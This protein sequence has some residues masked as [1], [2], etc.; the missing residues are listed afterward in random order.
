MLLTHEQNFQVYIY[1]FINLKILFY[2]SCK[3]IHIVP[4]QVKVFPKILPM[5]LL[6]LAIIFGGVKVTPVTFWIS[7]MKFLCQGAAMSGAAP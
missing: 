5:P 1:S 7:L 6:L 2:S 4:Q 3:T